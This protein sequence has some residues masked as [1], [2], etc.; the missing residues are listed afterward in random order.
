MSLPT[1][2]MTTLGSI[3]NVCH[4]LWSV[5]VSKIIFFLKTIY[6]P[7]MPAI[8]DENRDTNKDAKRDA[9]EDEE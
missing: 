1:A 3:S 8:L 4:M 2:T 5:T 9:K 6:P 7:W